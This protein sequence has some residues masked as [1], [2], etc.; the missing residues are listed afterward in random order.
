LRAAG[1][2]GTTQDNIQDWMS[3]MK[4]ALDFSFLFKTQD[5]G[6]RGLHDCV[7]SSWRDWNHA[8]QYPR[9]DELD[10]EG[11]GFQLLAEE[12]F[13]AVIYFFYFHQHYLY[14]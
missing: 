5:L 9:L 14:Y 6:A 13:A 8:R 11:P 2:T 4:K 1:E 7:E 12:E 10:E 3:W